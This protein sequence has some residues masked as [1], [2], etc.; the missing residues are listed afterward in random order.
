MRSEA[1][2]T[3]HSGVSRHS[4]ASL[5]LGEC[6]IRVRCVFSVKELRCW[7]YEDASRWLE[8]GTSH[9]SCNRDVESLIDGVEKSFRRRTRSGKMKNHSD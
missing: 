7:S 8:L 1:R 9:N 5:A 3:L 2:S 4:Q 6:M